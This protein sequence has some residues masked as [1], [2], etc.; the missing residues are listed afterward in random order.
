MEIASDWYSK[1][2]RQHKKRRR[3]ASLDEDRIPWM[4]ILE[5]S[6]MMPG[7]AI[8]AEMFHDETMLR[9]R[10]GDVV[11]CMLNGSCGTPR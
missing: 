8:R 1:V 3:D 2:I 4:E 11:H 6:S 10:P 5:V 7:I 9:H